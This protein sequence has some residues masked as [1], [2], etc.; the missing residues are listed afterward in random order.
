[1]EATPAGATPEAVADGFKTGGS[2]SDGADSSAAA[3]GAAASAIPASSKN[4]A[5]GLAGLIVAAAQAK[6]G[7]AAADVPP[8]SAEEAP[9]D[10]RRKGAHDSHPFF[11][12]YGMLVHQQNMLQDA[13]RT[14]AYQA[15]IMANA[16]DFRDK[17]VMD[18]G[19]GSGILAYFAAK[20]GARRVYAVEASNVADRAALLMRANGLA[21]RIIVLKAK[22]EEVELPEGEKVDVLISEP[23]GFMLV[24]ERMLE[25]YMIA[26]QMFL[27][28]GG[29]MFPSTGTIFAAPFTDAGACLLPR[30][31]H[32]RRATEHAPHHPSSWPHPA[33]LWQ[34]QMS[35][36]AFWRNTDFY[37]LD[38]SCLAAAA[39]T[40]HFSQPIVGYVD[41]GCLVAAPTAIKV[42]DFAADAPESLHVMD[43]PFDCAITRTALCHGLALWFDVSFDGSAVT[44][45]LSTAPTA[46]GTHWYQCRLLLKEP[47]ALNAN[48]RVEGTLHMVANARYSYNLTLTMRVAGSA[49]GTVDGR[50]I[51]SAVCVALQDQQYHYLTGAAAAAPAPA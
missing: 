33:A 27:K 39:A 48:Q 20:A 24:H 23:M 6:K 45:V 21:D 12:Y 37:G 40:D 41:A 2:S 50:P 4:I 46:A 11:S 18:V 8:F 32:P 13:V 35:K 5:L 9:V 38:I 44:Y 47:L 49:A 42:V 22:V 3:A 10:F 14:G 30:L 31:A 16:E 1:M 15:A 17:V 34:E 25:S 36:V 7:A 51:E 19:S 29:R 26:R 43:L 28:P